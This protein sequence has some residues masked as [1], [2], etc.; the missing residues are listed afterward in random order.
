MVPVNVICVVVCGEHAQVPKLDRGWWSLHCTR[1]DNS[2]VI[3]AEDEQPQISDELN[4][5]VVCAGLA[6]RDH[7][8]NSLTNISIFKG[9]RFEGCVGLHG[10][11]R[12]SS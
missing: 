12:V 1:L 8:R 6:M 4:N 7:G 3:Q 10:L 2:Y 5:N 9:S 11:M